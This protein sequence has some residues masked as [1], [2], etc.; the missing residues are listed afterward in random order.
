MTDE[1]RKGGNVNIG[2]V[3]AKHQESL[4]AREGVVAMAPGTKIVGGRDTGIPCITVFVE[5]KLP[6]AEVPAVAMIPRILED[7][8]T[9]VVQAGEVNALP[10]APPVPPTVESLSIIDHQS[11][12]RPLVAG[13]SI[14]REN[15][16]PCGTLGC[17][18]YKGSDLCMLSNNHVI[19]L[20]Y[21][22]NPNSQP[23]G[24]ERIRQPSLFD[25]GGLEDYVA[26][27][28]DWEPI[29]PGQ[30]NQMD[31]AIA[32]LTVP[33]RPELLELGPYNAVA[34]PEVSMA[35]AK[36]GRSSGVTEG[37][38]AYTGASVRVDYGGGLTMWYEGQIALQPSM[39]APG[40]SGSAIVRKA[41]NAVVALGFAGSST[42]SFAT[43]ISRVFERFGLRIRP[44]GVPIEEALASIA[45]KYEVVWGF[46]NK[47]KTFT[48]YDPQAPPYASDL[49]TLRKGDAYWIKVTETAVLNYGGG[50][51]ELTPDWNAIGWLEND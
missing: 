3:L 49:K 7:I 14:C 40:D 5:K 22:E 29:G 9:D 36:E 28:L 24:G 33:G 13:I 48:K 11:R 44:P 1:E 32:L 15:F 41:D 23:K 12:Q 51:V 4:K 46:D 27:L 37:L 26:T 2:E 34:D 19:A 47:G 50:E 20:S 17:I 25:G 6:A 18:A 10:S 45:G 42:I 39:L 30:T 16:L 43:P 21:L 35:V 38:V 8:P 31:A